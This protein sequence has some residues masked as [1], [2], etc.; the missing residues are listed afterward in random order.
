MVDV[1][2]LSETDIDADALDTDWV[3]GVRA[4]D[5]EIVRFPSTEFQGVEGKSAYEIAVLNGFVGTEEEWLE[6]LEG[7]PG[8]ADSAYDVAVNNGFVGTEAEWLASLVGADGADGTDGIDGT[9]GDS[10]YQV[11]VDNGFVGT[12]AEWLD[13]IVGKSAYEEAVDLGFVGD[14]AAWLLSLKGDNGDD[15]TNGSDGADGASAYEVAVAEGFVGDETAW[16]ASL[17]GDPGA[18]PVMSTTSTSSHTP[19][20]GSKTFVVPA[21]LA[22]V[23]G[24]YVRAQVTADPTRWVAGPITAYSTTNMTINVEDFAGTG[25]WGVWT[26]SIS[27]PR[28]VQGIQGV[29]GDTG[30]AGPPGTIDNYAGFDAGYLYQFDGGTVEGWAA[31]GTGASVAMSSTPGNLQFI[32][33]DSNSSITRNT[34][35]PFLGSKYP[36][37]RIKVTRISG[38]GSGSWRGRVDFSTTTRGSYTGSVSKTIADPVIAVGESEILTWDMSSLTAPAASTEWLTSQINGIRVYLNNTA[39][40]WRIDWIAIGRDAPVQAASTSGSSG[41]LAPEFGT[42]MSESN[43]F[44][45]SNTAAQN[46][47]ALRAVMDS[48]SPKII[49]PQ[50]TFDINGLFWNR[51]C[52]LFGQGRN[53]T[54]LQVRNNYHGLNIRADDASNFRMVRFFGFHMQH[55]G[56]ASDGDVNCCAVLQSCKAY[57]EECFF[58]GFPGY[59]LYTQER[60]IGDNTTMP[61]FSHYRNC[62]FR[63]SGMHNFV[64]RAGANANILENVAMDHSHTGCGFVHSGSYGNSILGG[65]CSYNALEGYR[66]EEGQNVWVAGIYAEGSGRNGG[67]A[68]VNTMY[69][70]YVSDSFVRGD[71]H[72]GTVPGSNQQH[73]RAPRGSSVTQSYVHMGRIVYSGPTGVAANA[74]PSSGALTLPAVSAAIVDPYL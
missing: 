70:V 40:E 63:N 14:E 65:Q 9:D 36:L 28:G 1:R 35:T 66:F 44:S 30:V 3:L 21:G 54:F 45:S 58:E 23:P 47:A 5:N 22:L 57:M 48:G 4:T 56:S 71:I 73:I 38:P 10:G 20:L 7:D 62:N 55:M 24:Q 8:G 6:S 2:K 60:T 43:G 34:I 52:A 26:I 72:I 53:Q 50:G 41:S 25:V 37:V 27:G 39:A 51:D 67:V 12:E 68:H 18:T 59:G 69:D 33:V 46:T 31:T 13:S 16:L 19:G 49:L 29:K 64:L 15:G 17:Q 32:S 74:T 61:F 11:A 42:Y